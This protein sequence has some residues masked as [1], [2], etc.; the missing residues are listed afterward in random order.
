MK[1]LLPFIL[2]IWPYMVAVLGK[3]ENENLSSLLSGLYIILT[4]VIYV[5]NIINAFTY[6]NS[7]GLALYNVLIKLVHIPFYL[8][9]FVLGLGFLFA[10]VVPAMIL[11]T[12]FL[13]VILFIV[14]VLLLLTTSM[15]GINAIRRAYMEGQITLTFAI[16]NGILHLFFVTDIV[17]AILVACKV[18][19]VPGYRQ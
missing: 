16:V 13:I 12:P 11:V 7:R 15:Y 8:I 18:K 3:V 14:D 17:S 4:V 10:S 2:M 6:R 1:K 9:I 19:K 5:L